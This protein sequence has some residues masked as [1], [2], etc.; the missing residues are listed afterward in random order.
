MR[1]ADTIGPKPHIEKVFRLAHPTAQDIY[2]R[3]A[4]ESP[5]SI[6]R[7]RAPGRFPKSGSVTVEWLV[8]GFALSKSTGLWGDRRVCRFDRKA[9][10]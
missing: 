3:P 1:C 4:S 10:L 9:R 7:N 8:V 6:R 5:E 2:I